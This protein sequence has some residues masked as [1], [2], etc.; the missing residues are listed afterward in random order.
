MTTSSRA[1]RL[2]EEIGEETVAVGLPDGVPAAA[3]GE[4]AEE[5][6]DVVLDRRQA[7][8][9]P[10]ADLLVREAGGEEAQDLQLATGQRLSRAGHGRRPEPAQPFDAGKGRPMREWVTLD[11]RTLDRWEPLALE[12]AAFTRR[13]PR[14]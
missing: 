11:E 2:V 8:R 14:P 7:D 3:D 9:Q 12:A 13:R 1:S 10:F 4:L 6:V 5:V